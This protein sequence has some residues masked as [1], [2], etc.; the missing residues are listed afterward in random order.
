MSEKMMMPEEYPLSKP[1]EQTDR[2][3]R[4]LFFR[5][6][7]VELGSLKKN[8]QRKRF[9]SRNLNFCSFAKFNSEYYV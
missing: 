4:P 9:D 8:Y 3:T 6:Y 7:L 5:S 2:K 1:K